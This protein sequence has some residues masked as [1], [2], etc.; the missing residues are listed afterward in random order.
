MNVLFYISLIGRILELVASTRLIIGRRNPAVGSIPTRPT[1]FI[2]PLAQ[3][4]EQ[5]ASTAL[6][7]SLILSWGANLILGV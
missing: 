6:V 4:I 5:R 3:W 1:K 7:G 2:A